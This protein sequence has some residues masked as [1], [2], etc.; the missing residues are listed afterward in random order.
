[1]HLRDKR[2]DEVRLIFREEG[3]TYTDT[4]GNSYLSMTTCLGRYKE[5]FD[6][7]YWLRK[8]SKEL[9]ISE[10]R[11]EQQWQT[12]TD[13]ACSRGTK[14]HDGIE[15]GVRDN[16]MFKEAVKY[17]KRDEGDM[18]TVADIPNLNMHI[19][20]LDIKDFI[21]ATQNKYPE[22]YS[23]LQ[24][25]IERDYKIYAEIGAFL[26][27]FLLSGMIDL[28]LIREDNFHIGDWKT[29]RG[30][31]IFESGYYKKD[32][33]QKPNQT[34]DIWIPKDERMLAPLNHIQHCNGNA[35]TLQLSGY[36][37]M[38]ERILGIPCKGLWLAHIDSDFVL[39]EYGMPKRFP[40][41]LYHIKREPV[42]KVTLHKIPYWRDDFNLILGDRIKEVD[43]TRL[44]SHTLFD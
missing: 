5:K 24:W 31:L 30:G 37:N 25:Y 18:I 10:K 8:K 2:Y 39:N 12:I 41:G 38:V 40:D 23:V 43:A 11:L 44:R 35:Y 19:K 27:D 33:E 32:K 22:I 26:I 14:T 3:H 29:N 28:L 1:M 15:N 36:A 20:Q 7:K 42:E 34:T 13:E 16:S 17:L 21:E 4:F 6:K 9:G